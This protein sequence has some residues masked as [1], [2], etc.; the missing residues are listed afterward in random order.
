MKRILTNKKFIT[1]SG[2]TILAISTLLLSGCNYQMIDLDYSY[3]KAICNIAG[4]YKEIEINKWT[5][6]EGEQLQIKGKDGNTYLV[7]SF[8]CTL[9]KE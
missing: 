1:V 6:Y 5:D 3:D 2:I 9:I 4:E 7:S 8:N